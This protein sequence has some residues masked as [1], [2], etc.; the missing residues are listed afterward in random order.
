MKDTRNWDGARKL[1]RD[2]FLE[3]PIE[4]LE[5]SEFETA[6]K[7]AFLTLNFRQIFVIIQRY[8]LHGG[9]KRGYS[10]IGEFINRSGENVRQHESKAL[11]KLR[12]PSSRLRRYAEPDRRRELK[13]KSE[14][15]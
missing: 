11:R 1:L 10:E 9:P 4:D 14:E 13:K 3:E 15:D 5:H 12:H 8:G 6:L 2:I 7:K